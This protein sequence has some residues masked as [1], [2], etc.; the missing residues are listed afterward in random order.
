MI[1]PFIASNKDGL[2]PPHAGGCWRV[3]PVWPP[4]HVSQHG[5][6]VRRQPAR[7]RGS[8]LLSRRKAA[9]TW[10]SPWHWRQN[11]SDSPRAI[12]LQYGCTP[13]PRR[14]R[15]DPSPSA[16][17][18]TFSTPVRISFL[19]RCGEMDRMATRRWYAL[20]RLRR[21]LNACPP[22]PLRYGRTSSA[23]TVRVGE[24]AIRSWPNFLPMTLD[25]RSAIPTSTVRRSLLPIGRRL[26]MGA[27][28][29]IGSEGRAR[30]KRLTARLLP[31]TLRFDPASPSGF[32]FAAMNGRRVEDTIDP[33]V[34][35][36]LAGAP[37]SGGSTGRYQASGLFPYFARV[38][39]A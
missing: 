9:V 10:F 3:A 35:T 33:I 4:P 19:V 34:R 14:G 25:C 12:R 21:L 11:P 8:S 31:D 20:S 26:S 5:V 27:A 17:R 6:D 22:E 24:L 36:L 37:C 7:P 15:W 32:T 23:R 1:M 13:V 29:R 18:T 16:T 39:V 38:D 28:T 30:A 2:P